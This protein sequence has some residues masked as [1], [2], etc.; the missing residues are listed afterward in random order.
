M[1]RPER[2]YH[3]RGGIERGAKYT[4]RD[5]YSAEAIGGGEYYPWMTRRE[6]KSEALRDGYKA[7][8]YR[9]GKPE[10]HR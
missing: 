3:F 2:I 1:N 9:D 6:C 5:G 4:W 10:A 8:F 7:V